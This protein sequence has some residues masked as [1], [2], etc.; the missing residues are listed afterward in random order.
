[1]RKIIVDQSLAKNKKYMIMD[2]DESNFV[3]V[4][5]VKA[6]AAQAT[7]FNGLC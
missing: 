7:Q 3:V 1:M 4:A 5:Y 2:M 6:M